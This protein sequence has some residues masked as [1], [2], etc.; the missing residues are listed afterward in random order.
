MINWRP[1]GLAVGNC[2]SP[3]KT[4]STRRSLVF[5]ATFVLFVALNIAARGAEDI[6]PP[7][8]FKWND[9]MTKLEQVLL[10][11]KA[12]IVNRE[13]KEKRDVWTV[14]GLVQPGLKRTLFTFR[15]GF[16][17]EVELQYEYPDWTIE[18]YNERMGEIRRYFDAKFGTGKLIS[19]SRDTESD[20]IQT[21]V[22]YQ[23]IVGETMLEL[24][25]FSAQRD[26][27]VF[28]S[29]TVTYKAI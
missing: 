24:F 10:G 25:Y 6:P 27:M 14:E 29:I 13:K 22:G 18:R 3:K 7:F 19:R 11:A 15:D 1:Q 17:V 26:Q 4:V 2:W 23:W 8:G 9:S 28:R 12:K 21:L 20:V 16:L 5:C